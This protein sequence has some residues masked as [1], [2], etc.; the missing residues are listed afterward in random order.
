MNK[1]N[2]PIENAI[3]GFRAGMADQRAG[4]AREKAQLQP[5]AKG[6]LWFCLAV[7]VGAAALVLLTQ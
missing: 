5:W 1:M 6:V 4:A 2:D 3:D 7:A